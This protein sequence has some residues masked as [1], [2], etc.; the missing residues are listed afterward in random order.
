MWETAGKDAGSEGL[1]CAHGEGERAAP[2]NRK[3]NLWRVVIYECMG[4]TAFIHSQSND[5]KCEEAGQ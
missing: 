4:N 2:D 1:H 3:I 5:R